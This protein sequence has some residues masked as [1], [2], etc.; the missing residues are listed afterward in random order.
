LQIGKINIKKPVFLAPMEDVTD[1]PFRR[2]CKSFGADVLTTEFVSSDA[3]VRN[4]KRTIS[5]MAFMEDERPIGIQ[6]YG[7]D[8]STMIEAAKI[9]E[10][11][12]PDFIDLNFGCPVKK[13]VRRG[14]GA[15]MLRD[16]PKMIEMTTKIVR[17][18][19]LPVSA[20]TRI[21]WDDSSMINLTDMIK[22]FQDTGI[23]FLTLHFRTRQQMYTGKADWSWMEKINTNIGI[24][25][26]IVGNGDIINGLFA[27]EKFDYYNVSGIMI[28]RASI[29]NPWIFKTIKA[30]LNGESQV[31]IPTLKEKV[32]VAIKHLENNVAYYGEHIGVKLMR[33]HFVQY[34]KGI[35]NFRQTKIKLLTSNDAEENKSILQFIANNYD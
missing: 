28:G 19:S 14:A 25:L 13:V 18:V 17:S 33:R 11:Q 30:E 31:K 27:K 24:S 1:I 26:P 15:G 22:K 3:L 7:H 21:G 35:P 32:A 12:K 20:K 4:V 5:K 16:I 9:V 34:F 8:I 29:G 10:E 2:L 23:Q 6:I